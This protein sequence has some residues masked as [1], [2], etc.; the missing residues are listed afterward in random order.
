MTLSGLEE[1][2]RKTESDGKA[3]KTETETETGSSQRIAKPGQ[4]YQWD[5]R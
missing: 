1:L 4:R 5:R 3:N 2:T